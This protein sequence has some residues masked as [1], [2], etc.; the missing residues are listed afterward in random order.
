[1]T[2]SL[3]IKLIAG[4]ISAYTLL[5]FIRIILTWIPGAAYSGFGRFL[6]SVCDPYLNLFRRIRW[7]RFG[8]FDFTPAIAICILI[9]LSTILGNFA[10]TQTFSIGIL[11][12]TLLSLAWSIFTSFIGFMIILLGI[13][14]VVMLINK[15]SNSQGTIWEQI[16]RSL[17]PFIFKI[18]NIFSGGRPVSY[19]SA[20][21]AGI[22]SLI[23]MQIGGKFII[24]FLASM[25]TRLPF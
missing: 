7:L 13:R 25:L 19:K 1:M 14:L 24:A 6:S 2:I 21:I 11:L 20:L 16:D 18:T 4:V 23:V 5:C 15:N 3:I 8:N 22:V 17:S 10:T 9:A 12:A